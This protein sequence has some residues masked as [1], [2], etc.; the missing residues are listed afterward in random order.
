MPYR[1]DPKTKCDV[2]VNKGGKW[3]RLNKK[4]MTHAEA[5][6]YLAAL[7]IHSGHGKAKGK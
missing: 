5:L 7:E 6:K 1:I 3:Q 2:Q 4:K